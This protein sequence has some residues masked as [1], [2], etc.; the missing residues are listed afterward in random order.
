MFSMRQTSVF[1][2][3]GEQSWDGEEVSRVCWERAA[4]DWRIGLDAPGLILSSWL[5]FAANLRI[6]DWS[7]GMAVQNTG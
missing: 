5:F 6:M 7:L 2:M 3:C 1:K 4:M